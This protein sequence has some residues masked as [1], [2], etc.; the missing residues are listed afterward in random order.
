MS[1]RS[2]SPPSVASATPGTEPGVVSERTGA[3]AGLTTL[4]ILAV[5][6][7]AMALGVPYF[8]IAF[9][10]G[11]GGVLPLVLAY[12]GRRDR[13]TETGPSETETGPRPSTDPRDD[14]LDVLRRQYAEGRLTDAAFERRVER[15]IETETVADATAWTRSTQRRPDDDG[16]ADGRGPLAETDSHRGRV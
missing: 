10:V 11:F 3:V 7:G 16:R 15:L 12:T 4:S 6:F 14:A 13:E 1:S 2:P 9:P 8:W 5:A